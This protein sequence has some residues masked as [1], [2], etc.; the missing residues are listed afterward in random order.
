MDKKRFQ[1]SHCEK[2]YSTKAGLQRHL[3]SAHQMH[4]DK[5]NGPTIPLSGIDL[6]EAKKKLRRYQYSGKNLA[7]FVPSGEI[8]RKRRRPIMKQSVSVAAD[9]D[10]DSTESTES[11]SELQVPVVPSSVQGYPDGPSTSAVVQ[12]GSYS[13]SPAYHL[14]DQLSVYSEDL[15]VDSHRTMVS[16]STPGASLS[17]PPLRNTTPIPQVQVTGEGEHGITHASG[18]Q[19]LWVP[20]MG[21]SSGYQLPGTSSSHSRYQIPPY[22]YRRVQVWAGL[23]LDR[24]PRESVQALSDLLVSRRPPWVTD[25]HLQQALSTFRDFEAGASTSTFS[26][27]PHPASCE[28]D[29]SYG[30]SVGGRGGSKSHAAH[31]CA[32]LRDT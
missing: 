32:S 23:T 29:H 17:V 7:T 6:V 12:G 4:L 25:D 19:P 22:N 31:A 2:H 3:I 13:S 24:F 10:S 28:Y 1:C 14:P 9:S 27:S 11:I 20:V 5:K 18:L 15:E 8:G 26:S 16:G 30:H 21:T